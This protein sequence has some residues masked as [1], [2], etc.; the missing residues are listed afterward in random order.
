MCATCW[1]A[2]RKNAG[3]PRSKLDDQRPLPVHGDWDEL[4][5]VVQNLVENAIKYARRGK[6]HR[7]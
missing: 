6:A 5:Q 1:R 4:V 7:D 2:W 3:V